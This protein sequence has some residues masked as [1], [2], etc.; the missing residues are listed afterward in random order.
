MRQPAAERLPSHVL[1]ERIA[2]RVT[3]RIARS[4]AGSQPRR[5][6]P[7]DG[8]APRAGGCA[9]APA[10]PADGGGDAERRRRLVGAALCWRS[11]RAPGKEAAGP[12]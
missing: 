12:R 8:A 11:Y 2:K 9:S 3:E 5:R 10:A 6:A 4:G 7:A 1:A